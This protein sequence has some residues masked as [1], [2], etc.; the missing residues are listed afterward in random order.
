MYL[1]AYGLEHSMRRGHKKVSIVGVGAVGANIAYALVESKIV[2][3]ISLIDLSTEHTE[4]E[5]F[6]LEDATTF[7]GTTKIQSGSDYRLCVDSDIIIITEK[8]RHF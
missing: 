8:D 4:G 2:D 3:E 7:C 5:V 1:K 6:D